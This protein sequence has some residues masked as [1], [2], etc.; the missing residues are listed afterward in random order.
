M[1]E[2]RIT[3]RLHGPLLVQG[4]AK[5]CDH[6]GNEYNLAGK[7]TY[8]LCRCDH[9]AKKPFCDGAHK[10]CGFNADGKAV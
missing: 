6:E 5:L 10:T 9:S 3:T 2:V 4:P 7:E 8:A 1:T